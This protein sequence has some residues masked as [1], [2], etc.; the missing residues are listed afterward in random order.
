MRGFIYI[1]LYIS[2]YINIIYT[3]MY[4]TYITQSIVYLVALYMEKIR[5]N[6]HIC[7]HVW[8]YEMKFQFEC[9]S[10]IFGWW[11]VASSIEIVSWYNSCMINATILHLSIY[12]SLTLFLECWIVCDVKCATSVLG[13]F[14]CC[15]YVCA[16]THTLL[17]A[18]GK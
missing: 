6:M 4:I 12:K 18:A 10:C 9:Y 13:L 1:H 14:C 8:K 17:L 5:C 2:C 11:R 15:M 16:K 7:I 3:Y